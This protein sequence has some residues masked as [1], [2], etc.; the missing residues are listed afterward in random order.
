[1]ARAVIGTVLFSC[2]YNGSTCFVI[3]PFVSEPHIFYYILFS[4]DTDSH[5]RREVLLYHL[6]TRGNFLL[7]MHLKTLVPIVSVPSSR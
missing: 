7:Y 6:P 2:M 3:V 5:Q 1:M 4:G